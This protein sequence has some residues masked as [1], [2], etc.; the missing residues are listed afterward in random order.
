M[1]AVPA[2]PGRVL[3]IDNDPGIHDAIRDILGTRQQLEKLGSRVNPIVEFARASSDDAPYRVECALHAR[4][5]LV[6]LAAAVEDSNPFDVAFVDVCLPLGGT[7]LE[8]MELLWDTDPELHV[9]VCTSRPDQ[10]WGDVAA[11]FGVRDNLLFVKKPFHAAEI[12][13][14]ASVLR[15]K[16]RLATDAMDKMKLLSRLVMTRTRELEEAHHESES[17]L[18]AIASLLIGLD[19][20]GT[21]T[22][23]NQTAA[24]VFGIES[25]AAI[26]QSL[27]HLPIAW[28]DRERL[29]HFLGTDDS[30]N[31]KRV[32]VCFSD[33]AGSRRL[34]AF[35]AYRVTKY[36]QHGGLLLLGREITE[37][38]ALEIH[39]QQARKLEAIGQLAA[40]VAHEINTPMQYIGDNLAYLKSTF[41]RLNGFV[42]PCVRLIE[43]GSDS[44]VVP[45]LVAEVGSQMT[46]TRWKLVSAQIEE[47]LNDSTEGVQHVSRIVRALKEF[48]H[49]D[50]TESTPVDLNRALETTVTIAKSEWK[51]VATV[52]LDLDPS[53]RFVRALAGDLNQVFLNLIVN[54]AQAIETHFQGRHCGR[55]SISTQRR[56]EFARIAISDNGGGI[57][58]SV[59]DRVF[60]PFFTTKDIGKGTGQGLALAHSVIVAKHQGRIW[61]E[62]DEGIGTTFLIE[63]PLNP[64][65]CDATLNADQATIALEEES[66]DAIAVR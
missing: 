18:A 59:R 10:T 41:E 51:Y 24:A 45:K 28:T 42:E 32:E 62:V 34:L 54:S 47:A 55:I 3:V 60:D 40:G 57:P 5:G 33:A 11:N 15:A 20:G 44:Q 16:R 12:A 39:H 22:R 2:S 30:E 37:Q 43:A 38:R 35:T 4:D 36:E 61:F 65:E 48:S 26:G 21:I 49:P 27:E 52:D 46:H 63:I 29:R 25:D 66:P 17:H 8:M 31:G 13:Q 7:D 58:P 53:L 6:L 1:A 56:G 14:C 50:G 19:P 64:D 23:W 9:V